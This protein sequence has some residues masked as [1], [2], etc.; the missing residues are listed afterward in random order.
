VVARTLADDPAKNSIVSTR[1]P[2]QRS[3]APGRIQRKSMMK[4]GKMSQG[5]C[6]SEQNQFDKVYK[7][8]NPVKLPCTLCDCPDFIQSF[9]G[10][11]TK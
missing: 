2:D 3:L 4:G 11:A 1:R 7:G 8:G 6:S 10:E 9:H 5:A